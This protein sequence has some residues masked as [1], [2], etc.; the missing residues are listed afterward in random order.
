MVSKHILIWWSSKLRNWNGRAFV[1]TNPNI[2]VKSD[3]SLISWSANCQNTN[4]AGGLWVEN[5]RD[6]H[7][8]ALEFKAVFQ[9]IQVKSFKQE[10]L[11]PNRANEQQ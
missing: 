4:T 9:A 8:N 10:A 3:A 5:E 6:Q 7:L 11:G 1:H 2:A